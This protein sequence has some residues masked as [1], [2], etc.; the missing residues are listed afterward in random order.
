MRYNW[1]QNDW[2]LFRYDEALATSLLLPFLE[3]VGKSSGFMETLS[4]AEQEVSVINVLVKEAIKTSEIEGE[5]ISRK[6]VISSIRK[7][8]GFPTDKSVIKDKRSEGLGEL[9]IKVRETF[10]KPLSE[11]MLFDWHKLL[12][13]GSFGVEVGKWRSHEEP[14]QVISGAMGKEKVHFEAPPSQK[15]PEEMTAFVTWFNASSPKGQ[16]KLFNPMLRAAITHLYFES[17]HPF[18]DGNGRI[19][20]LLAEKALAQGLGKPVFMS[21][22]KSIEAGKKTYYRQ[23]EKAQQGNEITKWV[24]Y[25]CGLL[26]DAQ[27]DFEQTVRFSLK[28]ASFFET[29][30]TVLN[31]RQKKVIKKMLDEGYEGF[32]GGM[33]TRKYIGLT[34]T[35]KA[36]ATRDLQDLV[37]KGIFISAGGGRSVSYSLKIE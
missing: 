10:E 33:N 3:K 29:H 7:N 35:S 37:A 30:K 22:S 15:V 9:L 20:R 18:E 31:E 34:K 6:D 28:K 5:Y 14:M 25:F 8:L 23:L 2:P 36:T 21:L 24:N 11:K 12:M 27:N 17:V 4:K 1:Q 13:K 19:G 16:Q 32:E 26:V